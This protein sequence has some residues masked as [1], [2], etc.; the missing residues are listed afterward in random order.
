MDESL[1]AN[2]TYY[3]R[4]YAYTGVYISD[5]SSEVA[6]TTRGA[7][8]LPQN[9]PI[10]LGKKVISL[11][12]GSK[13]INVDNQVL[14]MDTAPISSQGRTMLP[15]RYVT[16]ALGATLSWD[17]ATQKVTIVKGDKIIELWIGNNTARVNGQERLIDADNPEVR[18]FIAP[19]GRTMLPLRF[20]SEN[21]GCEVD[22]DPVLQMVQIH[23]EAP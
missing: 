13:Q 5:P 16:D 7:L 9:G 22:W 20:I 11:S 3:Y 6:V 19:P 23:Y 15:I 21:L 8:T 17:A 14:D 4:C 12:L 10:V 18:P 1:A 2:T